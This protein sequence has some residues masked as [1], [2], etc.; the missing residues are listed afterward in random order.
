MYFPYG[1]SW[2]KGKLAS[3][4]LGGFVVGITLDV[5]ISIDACQLLD[6]KHVPNHIH[7]VP[8]IAPINVG[9]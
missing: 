5:A 7:A 1:F 8:N 3:I 2:E 6:R 4:L 9:T